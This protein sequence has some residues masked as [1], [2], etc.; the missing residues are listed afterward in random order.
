M[1]LVRHVGVIS[2]ALAGEHSPRLCALS[3]TELVHRPAF[4]CLTLR[5]HDEGWPRLVSHSP[6]CRLC[7]RCTERQDLITELLSGQADIQLLVHS[8]L[9]MCDNILG[10]LKQVD[11]R[12][13]GIYVRGVGGVIM[14][15]YLFV[16]M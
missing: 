15:T 10:A 7:R 3:A 16:F 9:S 6:P 4:A 11:L 12:Y 5:K 13:D 1:H 2:E 14:I 8:I